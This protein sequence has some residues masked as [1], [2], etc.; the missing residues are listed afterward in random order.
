[1]VLCLTP[2]RYPNLFYDHFLSD[3]TVIKQSGNLLIFFIFALCFF[4]SRFY[5]SFCLINI[6]GVTIQTAYFVYHITLF[7]FNLFLPNFMKRFK[8]LISLY[9]ILKLFFSAIV[10][11]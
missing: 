9:T 11:N 8:L 6:R 4:G 2:E 1:M 5:F 10:L 7:H 3:I